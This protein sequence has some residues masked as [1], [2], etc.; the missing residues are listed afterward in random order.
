MDQN[1]ITMDLPCPSC[2]SFTLVDDKS[3]TCSHCGYATRK[4]ELTTAY[5]YASFVFRY[6]HQFRHFYEQ[7][8]LEKGEITNNADLEPPHP[9]HILISLPLISGISGGVSWFLVKGAISTIVANYNK[10]NQTDFEIPDEDLKILNVNFREFINN[11]ADA[12]SRLRNA[13]FEAMFASE[14]SRQEKKKYLQLQAQIAESSPGQKK[15]LEA[16]AEKMLEEAMKKTFKKIAARPK[17]T[18][19]ELSQ[20]WL[21]IID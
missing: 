16:R 10:R 2:A 12:D 13:V 5:D 21:K 15:E 18:P 7:Q 6:G 9:L 17:P 20:F 19:E 11:F 3:I 4:L 8:L 14:C 1:S